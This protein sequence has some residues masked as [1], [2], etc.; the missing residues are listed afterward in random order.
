M[1][2]IEQIQLHYA[3]SIGFSDWNDLLKHQ[4]NQRLIFR[5]YNEVSKRYARQCIEETIKIA[6][7]HAES[8]CF[9]KEGALV[10]ALNLL[11]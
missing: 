10:N 4:L 7:A 1:K 9:D 6:D 2:T 5:D 11:K 3:K 8:G